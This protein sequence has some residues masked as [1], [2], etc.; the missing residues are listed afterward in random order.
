MLG[1]AVSYPLGDAGP[2][3]SARGATPGAT[4]V[5]VDTRL[6]DLVHTHYASL[7]RVLRRLGVADGDVDDAL[8]QVF[9]VMSAQLA[10]L[11]PEAERRFV[12]A[13]A[14]RV[15]ANARRRDQ[16]RRRVFADAP[17][18]DVAPA[19]SAG[20][21]VEQRELREQLDRALAALPE[22]LRTVLVLFE[23]EELSTQEI[24]ECLA[25]PAGTVASRLRRARERFSAV[26]HRMRIEGG[27]S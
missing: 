26:A 17:S 7:W 18:D 14:V 5:T 8:Q 10:S 24:A 27:A 12:Y 15:A 20:C 22:E 13:V 16:R 23:L 19:A 4:A 11:P 6:R 25:L 2:A 3:P 1:E 9:L 21:P